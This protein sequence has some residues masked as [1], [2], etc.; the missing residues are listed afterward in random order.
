MAN[1]SVFGTDFGDD[2]KF[3]EC[4]T[5][6]KAVEKWIALQKKY[7]LNVSIEAKDE[8]QAL[9]LYNWVNNNVAQVVISTMSNTPYTTSHIVDGVHSRLEDPSKIDVENLYPFCMG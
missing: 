2:M 4:S 9:R 8:K 1:Y 6:E 5:P 7:P 3:I